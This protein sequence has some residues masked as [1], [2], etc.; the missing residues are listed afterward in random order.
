M[1]PKFLKWHFLIWVKVYKLTNKV[2]KVEEWSNYDNYD[3]IL[4]VLDSMIKII[5]KRV[6]KEEFSLFY[7]SLDQLHQHLNKH[8]KYTVGNNYY[9]K[10]FLT[11]LFYPVFFE[12]I[13]HFP[14]DYSH[15]IWK[16]FPKEWK[17][18]K[19]KLENEENIILNTTLIEFLRWAHG[20]IWKQEKGFDDKLYDVSENLFPE[21]NPTLWAQILIFYFYFLRNN[22]DLVNVIEHL[23][24]FDFPV[25]K[26]GGGIE[27]TFELVYAVSHSSKI[28][29]HLSKMFLHDFSEVFSK[30]NLEKYIIDLEKL[31]FSEKS[32]EERK[33]QVLLKIFKQMSEFLDSKK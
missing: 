3:S 22:R 15:D 21:V 30:E 5:Q 6:L 23:W 29:S 1:L 31:Q 20:R 17:I 11:D 25:E 7:V 27:N 16:H 4:R 32:Q 13:T 10:Y 2:D 33:Q 14:E 9:V 24:N 12:N 18:T 8:Q 26:E 28:S 19:G